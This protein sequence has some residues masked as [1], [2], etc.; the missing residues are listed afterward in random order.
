LY[1]NVLY[2][3]VSAS[4]RVQLH[5]RIGERGEDLY[6]E[7]AGEI[8]AELAMHFERGRDYERATKYLQ[9]AAAVAQRLYANEE[10]GSL[11]S[12]G[13]ALLERLPPGTQ[14]DAQE[15]NLRLA[16]APLYRMTKGWTSPDVEQNLDRAMELC[17]KVGDDA[18]RAQVLYGLEFRYLVQARLEEVQWASDELHRLYQR[19]HAAPPPLEAETI[20]AASH[21]HLGGI[22]EASKEFESM[23]SANKHLS[24]VQGIVEQQGWNYAV[25]GRAW[26]SHALWLLG[27]PRR[28]MLRLHEGVRLAQDL[29]Q[30]FN[31]VMLAT[32]QAMLQQWCADEA[33]ARASAEEALALAAEYK[34]PYY[35]AWA[36][37]LASYARACEQPGTTTIASLRESIAAFRAS[38][39]R[40]RLPYYFGLLAQ[41]CGRAG[42]TAQ[43]LAAVDEGMA[44]SRAHNERWWDAELHRLRGELLLAGSA[45][46]D[47]AQTAL[48]RAIEIARTQ[49]ARALELRAATSLSRL[50]RAKRRA[51]DARRLLQ[52]GYSWFTEGF[53]TMDL[54]EAKA[55]LDESQ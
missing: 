37:I 43:G 49:Q 30:P 29:D 33:T 5:R 26:H 20:L 42:W 23:L 21:M 32:Y 41:A 31:Q 40:L 48:L 55:L 54:R 17:D 12:R 22:A 11:L 19:T 27:F 50:W 25:T 10:A 36:A 51:H 7:R 39:A 52:D 8:A 14:R 18:Q 35:R 53:D 47:E 44:A 45:D 6:G 1:Q 46:A 4:R 34:A 15:L 3:R 13:L 38:G 2:E 24:Q 28:A 9:Q 16:L